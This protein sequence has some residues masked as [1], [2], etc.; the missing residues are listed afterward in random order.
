[1]D[2]IAIS[3]VASWIGVPITLAALIVGYITY[4]VQR[5]KKRLQYVVVSRTRIVPP[6]VSPSLDVTFRGHKVS[7]ASIV[8]I[9]IVNT[10]DK[11][12][13][14]EDFES[15]MRIRLNGSSEAAAAFITR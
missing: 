6:D 10:G 2:R 5:G 14:R 7:D 1:M 12:I 3:D 11:A 9:R 4:R 15:D 8:V 13:P